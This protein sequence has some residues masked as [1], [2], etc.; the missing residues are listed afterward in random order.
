VSELT[1]VVVQ[2]FSNE[3]WKYVILIFV[4]NVK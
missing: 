2:E 3:A 1:L 4:E